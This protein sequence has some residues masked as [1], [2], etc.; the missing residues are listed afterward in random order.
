[1]DDK[2]CEVFLKHCKEQKKKPRISK[3]IEAAKSFMQTK[4]NSPSSNLED[5]NLSQHSK[6][7]L[8]L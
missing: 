2:S 5:T 6:E 1:M 3:I 4:N 8:T 7:V